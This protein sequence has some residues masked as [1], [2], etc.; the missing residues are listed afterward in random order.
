MLFIVSECKLKQKTQF[1][2]SSLYY[3]VVK[4]HAGPFA[5]MTVVLGIITAWAI[6]VFV[7][8]ADMINA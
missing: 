7:S 5:D 1:I 8:T 4:T 3:E 6:V 2:N